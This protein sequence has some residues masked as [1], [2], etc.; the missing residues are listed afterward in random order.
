MTVAPPNTPSWNEK[1]RLAALDSYGIMDS[2]REG[3][4]DDIVRVAA[5]ICGV[6]MA[7]ISLVDHERQWFK[8][9][10]GIAAPQTP[11][12]VAFCAHAIQQDGQFKVED[13]SVDPR[14]SANPLVTGEMGLRFYVGAPLVTPDGLPLG[15]LCVLDDKPNAL[16]DDQAF[17]LDALA[18]QVM[19][20]LELRKALSTRKLMADELNHRVKNTL[21]IAQAIVSQSVKTSGSLAEAGR[22]IEDRLVALGR[23][24]DILTEAD[25]RAASVAAIV[26]A[27]V[28]V[29][30][31]HVGQI[32]AEGPP[33]ALN[34]QA[35]VALSMALHE[36][37]TNAAKYGALATPQGKV[38]IVWSVV[39]DDD[40][41]PVFDLSWTE[42]NGPTVI[43][44]TRRGFGSR[45][46]A[47]PLVGAAGADSRVAYDPAGVIWRTTAPLT[48]IAGG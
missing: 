45:L 32:A 15:T 20:Q 48:E 23:T 35:T 1:D 25:W 47:S 38:S 17:A 43:A 14:F 27:A 28:K 30:A 21:A 22:I 34:P 33:V 8:A 18:R 40:S 7:L 24:H 9:A 3:E 2:A 19:A 36:L 39:R 41:A 44:P 10:V 6:P 29:H 46:I 31:G 11:R 13:A 16:S 37:A 4:F 5:L 26:D 42:S 12:D